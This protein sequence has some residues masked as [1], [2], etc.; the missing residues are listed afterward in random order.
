MS[1]LLVYLP[2]EGVPS[3]VDTSDLR[4]GGVQNCVDTSDLRFGGV[5]KLVYLSSSNHELILDDESS[6]ELETRART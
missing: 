2:E 3:G 6:S 4:F 1:A 5:K